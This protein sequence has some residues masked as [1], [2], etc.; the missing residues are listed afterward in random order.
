MLWRQRRILQYSH[1]NATEKLAPLK[2][3]TCTT[4]VYRYR[5]LLMLNYTVTVC[6]KET[7]E[8]NPEGIH[9]TTSTIYPRSTNFH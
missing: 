6:L 8:Y 4:T 5:H 7:I 9:D 1:S 2:K 3:E